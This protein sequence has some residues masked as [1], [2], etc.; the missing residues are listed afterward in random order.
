MFG[1]P[2]DGNAY[3]LPRSSPELCRQGLDTKVTSCMAFIPP[4]TIEPVVEP[5]LVIEYS[6]HII[7]LS[8]SVLTA[9]GPGLERISLHQIQTEQSQVELPWSSLA[10]ELQ[11]YI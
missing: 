8:M 6:L 7:S 9:R 5:A 10:G 3:V 11:T 1:E 4:M 2:F